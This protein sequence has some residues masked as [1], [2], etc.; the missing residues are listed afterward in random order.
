MII[1]ETATVAVVASREEHNLEE[2]PY[3]YVVQS[4]SVKNV[5]QDEEMLIHQ[6]RS[7]K[8]PL[9][10]KYQRLPDEEYIPQPYH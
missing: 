9:A 5:P 8:S 10:A 7:G 3:S 4:A 1:Y 6:L 2:T